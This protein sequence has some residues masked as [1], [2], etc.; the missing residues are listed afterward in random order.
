[1]VKAAPT[2]PV[3]KTVTPKGGLKK[4]RLMMK[5]GGRPSAIGPFVFREAFGA[6]VV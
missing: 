2:K 3:G 4:H 6:A 5:T 1:M